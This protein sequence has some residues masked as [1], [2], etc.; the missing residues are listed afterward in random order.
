MQLSLNSK[1]CVAATALVVL[2]LGITAAVIGFKSSASAE[3]AAMAL[4][5]TSAR[6]VAGALQTRIGTICPRWSAWPAP[7]AAR[8]P[9]TS[10]CSAAR[11]MN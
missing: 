3:A 1:I 4:A 11:S 8:A 9:P 2:S 10:P 5:R 7:C 6:E